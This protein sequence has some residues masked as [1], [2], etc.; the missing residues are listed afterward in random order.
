VV[1]VGYEAANFASQ[2]EY[3][4]SDP[5][6]VEMLAVVPSAGR[7]LGI[8]PPALAR[9]PTPTAAGRQDVMDGPGACHAPR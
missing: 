8:S 1:A 2:L 6:M 3:L 7:M 9:P 5:A 4:L